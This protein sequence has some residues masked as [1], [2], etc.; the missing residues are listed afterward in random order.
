MTICRDL[1]VAV[2]DRSLSLRSCEADPPKSGRNKLRRRLSRFPGRRNDKHCME[3]ATT[4]AE[5]C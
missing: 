1:G 5:K 4:T 2:V 3:A